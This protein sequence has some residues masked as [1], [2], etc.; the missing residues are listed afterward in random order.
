MTLLLRAAGK[1]LHRRRN[2]IQWRGTMMQ[3]AS[4]G[5]QNSANVLAVFQEIKRWIDTS[6]WK[7]DE[8]ARTTQCNLGNSSWIQGMR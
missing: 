6:T 7:A 4:E 1:T 5:A 8:T 2:S 3:R